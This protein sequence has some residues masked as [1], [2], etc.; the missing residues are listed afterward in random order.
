MVITD[1]AMPQMNGIELAETIKR[2]NS[3]IPV[4]LCTGVSEALSSTELKSRGISDI[5]LK[6]VFRNE[7]D[8]K[9]RQILGSDAVSAPP[10]DSLSDRPHS[11]DPVR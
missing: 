8:A 6:P 2:N 7:L 9:I 10:A 11:Q 1:Y 4:L 3:Q 5:L